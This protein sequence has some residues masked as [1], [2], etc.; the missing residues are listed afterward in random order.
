M[1]GPAGQASSHGA[2]APVY[3][4]AN[5]VPGAAAQPPRDLG[6]GPGVRAGTGSPGWR[7]SVPAA[8]QPA[9]PRHQPAGGQP[10]PPDVPGEPATGRP[11]RGWEVGGTHPGLASWDLT[12]CTSGPSTEYGDVVE[13]LW[14]GPPQGHGNGLIGSQFSLHLG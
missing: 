10:T 11:D 8:Q 1:R 14:G 4:L 6:G 13:R 9:A 7:P 12:H 3:P 5:P 2:V